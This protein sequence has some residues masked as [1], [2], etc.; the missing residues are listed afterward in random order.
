MSHRGVVYAC[1]KQ[2]SCFTVAT[3]FAVNDVVVSHTS[4]RRES[5]ALP[6]SPSLN[7]RYTAICHA[8]PSE[9]SQRNLK[10]AAVM[11][12]A[13]KCR[14]KRHESP[15]QEERRRTA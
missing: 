11:P 9:A 5:A 13:S 3:S 4:E 6:A 12:Y 2:Q 15:R 14:T 7:R 1:S 8:C 10:S